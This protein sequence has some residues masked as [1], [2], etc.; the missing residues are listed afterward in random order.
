M[1]MDKMIGPDFEAGLGLVTLALQNRVAFPDDGQGLLGAAHADIGFDHA[2]DERGLG[3]AP[4][5]GGMRAIGDVAYESQLS[6]RPGARLAV[7]EIK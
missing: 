2:L 5:D 1:D 6:S 4:F 7:V 3:L